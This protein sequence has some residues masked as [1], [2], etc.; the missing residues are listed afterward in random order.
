MYLDKGIP[1]F[2]RIRFADP[3]LK[4]RL[5][6]HTRRFFL[7]MNQLETRFA[8][9]NYRYVHGRYTSEYLGFLH[10]RSQCT[11]KLRTSLPSWPLRRHRSTSAVQVVG[12]ETRCAQSLLEERTS[13][14]NDPGMTYVASVHPR[15]N[16]QPCFGP[17][18]P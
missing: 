15:M 3:P 17:T 11:W 18:P 6:E 1:C 2:G 4:P 16:Y 10:L 12:L 13:E 5:V 14:S 9:I 7:G 8:R